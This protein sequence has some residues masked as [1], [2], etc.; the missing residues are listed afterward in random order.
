M[1]E[2]VVTDLVPLRYR[3]QWA[4]LIAAMWSLG[5]V[6]GPVIGGA[7]AIV[8]WR[9]IFWYAMSA[10]FVVV[11]IVLTCLP[12]STYHSSVLRTSWCRCFFDSTLFLPA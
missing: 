12:G 9:W 2:I 8:Q 7:F 6:S 10:S 4:G 1:T 3:G 5:S 11:I